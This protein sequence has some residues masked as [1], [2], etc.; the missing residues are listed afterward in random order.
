MFFVT[1]SVSTMAIKSNVSLSDI[2]SNNS[3]STPSI[4]LDKP[5]NSRTS[6]ACLADCA[7]RRF[8]CTFGSVGGPADDSENADCKEQ[9]LDCVMGCI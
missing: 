6:Q 3:H 5:H 8:D 7:Q 9:W 2:V 4:L 1:F